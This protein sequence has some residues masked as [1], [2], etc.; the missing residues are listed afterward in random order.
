MEVL[1][2]FLLG[3]PWVRI[4]VIIAVAIIL[5]RVIRIV[6]RRV[7][8]R[9]VRREEAITDADRDKREK[10]ISSIFGTALAAVLWIITVLVILSELHI[11]I[12]ALATGAGLAGIIIGF[13]AQNMIKDYLA[14]MFI[15]IENQYRVG[16]VVIFEGTGSSRPLGGI[17]E[18][19]S[20]RS[21]RIRDDDGNLHIVLNGTPTSVTNMTFKHANAHMDLRV[22]YNSNID[23][24]EQVINR[25]G[26]EMTKDKNWM[27]KIIEPIE[28]VRVEQFADSAIVIKCIG[29]TTPIDQW[30]VSGEFRRRLK[31]AFDKEGIEIPF[32]QMVIHEAPKPKAK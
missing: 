28:F 24:V 11:N 13:G 4:L 26:I 20:I 25:V 8:H 27:D 9:L 15:I 2:S 17:V 22:S 23:Q 1:E 16:D 18:E 31:K 32:N 19:I 30:A 6:V 3:Y 12:A 7:V 21:T 10:T 5:Q 29:K 14:G